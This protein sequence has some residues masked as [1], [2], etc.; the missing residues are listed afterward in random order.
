[1]TIPMPDWLALL[2]ALPAG[3]VLGVVFFGGLWWTLRRALASS[4]PA[5]WL[6]TSLLL[7]MGSALIGLYA[8]GGGHW[9]RLL[10][11]LAGFLLARIVVVRLTQARV[12][13]RS[14]AMQEM[15]HAPQR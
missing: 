1:M 12:V 7:R 10:V 5:R 13:Q 11:C 14:A 8:V 4:R 2:L 15:G 6:F 3:G 9:Q